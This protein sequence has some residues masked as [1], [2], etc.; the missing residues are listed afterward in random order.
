MSLVSLALRLAT[1]EAV[2][3]QTF[4][5]D[6][7]LDSPL[8]PFDLAFGGEGVKRPLI[9]V[10]TSEDVG[11]PDGRDLLC[12][13]R[14]VDLV[15]QIFL[16]P[17]TAVPST[18]GATGL[19]MGEEG[20]DA[21]LD[22]VCRA[23]VRCLVADGSVWADIW[24]GL[25]NKVHEVAARPYIVEAE[26][27]V[28]VAAREF[29][30]SVDTIGDPLFEPVGDGTPWDRL[31][32][33]LRGSPDPNLSRIAG[34]VEAAISG[35]FSALTDWDAARQ[36]LGISLDTAEALGIAPI[37]A[38]ADQVQSWTVAF[39]DEAPLTVDASL[40]VPTP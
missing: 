37:A 20:A 6:N 3:G 26:N 16:P 31:V 29:S 17:T 5:G 23:V 9:A 22:L 34:V 21:A 32:S 10:Y 13:D 1:I 7:V 2:R 18:D 39:D 24:Q 35:D 38:T 25:V 14:R 19:R 12:P 15:L 27:H 36:T 30:I 28:R 11:R 40:Q 8:D 4:A 33:A